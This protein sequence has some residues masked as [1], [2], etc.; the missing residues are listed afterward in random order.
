MTLLRVEIDERCK[1]TVYVEVPES[2]D[3]GPRG[4]PD[5]ANYNEDGKDADG[6]QPW[7]PPDWIELGRQ[8]AIDQW[9]N[10]DARIKMTTA[11]RQTLVAASA[12]GAK[13]AQAAEHAAI[14]QRPTL[15]P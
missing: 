10:E 4:A 13:P 12:G 3:Y 1:R 8:W 5:P 9:D 7:H 11:R 14:I 6:N 2:D 15:T